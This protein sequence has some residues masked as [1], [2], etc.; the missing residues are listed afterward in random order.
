MRQLQEDYAEFSDANDGT[1]GRNVGVFANPRIW[2]SA[3]S[4]VN[5]GAANFLTCLMQ[6]KAPYD[7]W[8]LDVGF[9][10]V[11]PHRVRLF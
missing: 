4:A 5:I 7:P 2:P 3:L 11:V 10:L 6:A 9:T 8:H 1:R